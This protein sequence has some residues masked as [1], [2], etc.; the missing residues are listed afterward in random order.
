MLNIFVQIY[1][2]LKK[3]IALFV[4]ILVLIFSAIAYQ[5]FNLDLEEDIQAIIPHDERIDNLS[6]ALN[7]SKFSDQIVVNFSFKDTSLTDPEKLKT[8]AGAFVDMVRRDT[9]LVK[10]IRFKVDNM[11][12]RKVYGFFYQYLPFYLDRENYKEIEARLTNEEIAKQLKKNYKSLISPASIVTKRFLFKDPLSFTPV[13]LKKLQDLQL[14]DN[15]TIYKSCIFTSDRKNLLVFIEPQY[16]SG[17]TDKNEALISTIDTA[18]SAVVEQWPGIDL[19]YY[20]GTAVAVANAQRIKTDIIYTISIAV[21][22]IFLLFLLF[23]KRL[24]ILLLFFFPVI[25]GAGIGI[26]LLSVIYGEISAISLSIGAI[27]VGISIDYSLHAFTHFRSSGS[28]VRTLKD[29]AAPILISSITTGSAFLCLIVLKSDALSQ[30]GTF[31]AISVFIAAISVLFF[32]PQFLSTKDIRIKK[33]SKKSGL[34]KIAAYPIHEK[35]IALLLVLLLSVAFIFTFRHIQFNSNIDSL[36]YLTPELKQAEKDLQSIS[37]VANSTVFLISSGESFEKALAKFEA[38]KGIIQQAKDRNLIASISKGQ[39]FILTPEEQRKKIA[40]WNAFWD[41]IN[42]SK[43]LQILR[44]KG[45]KYHFKPKAF[46]AFEELINRKF[47]PV[48]TDEFDYIRNNFLDTYFTE[49]NGRYSVIAYVKVENKN[50]EELQNLF[51][52]TTDIVLFSKQNFSNQFFEIIKNQFDKLVWVT[53]LVVFIVLLIAYGRFELALVTFVPIMLS[54]LWTLGLIG[55]FGI[56]LN[57]FNIIISTFIFGLGVDYCIFITRGLVNNYKYGNHSIAPYKLSVLLSFITT[58]VGIGVLVFA[59]HPALKSIALVSVFG[60]TSVVIV[61]FTVLPVLFNFLIEFKGKRRQEPVTLINTMAS[62][63]SLI[64]FLISISTLTVIIPLFLLLSLFARRKAK[65]AYNFLLSLMSNFVVYI[66]NFHVTKREIDKHKLDFSK[67]AVLAANHQSHLD[68]VLL[69]KMNPRIIILTNHWV[70]H[71]KLF[72]FI[73]RFAD[74]YPVYKGLDHDFERISKKVNEGYSILVFP[75]GTRTNDGKIKRYH[76]GVFKIADDLNLEIQPILLHGAYNAMPRDEF[77]LRARNITLKYFDRFKVN[78]VNIENNETYRTQA[79]AFTSFVRQEYLNLRKECETPAFFYKKTINQYIFKGPVL[80]WYV[81]I[82]LRLEKNYEAIHQLI[83]YNAKIVDLGCGYGYM[84]Y[85]LRQLSDYRKITGYDYDVDKIAIANQIALKDNNLNFYVK[86]ISDD[87]FEKADVYI[88]ND[89][90]HYLPEK[91]QKKVI[92]KCMKSLNPN[93]I[94]IIRDADA[95]LKKR[96]RN[97]KITEFFSTKVLKFN[98]TKYE[99]TFV[100]GEMVEEIAADNNFS[101]NIINRTNL[102]PNV[103]F[104]LKPGN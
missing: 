82:K 92:G 42:R 96:T 83:P 32:L 85:M 69:M 86:D 38:N 22:F 78:S 17:N 19:N 41:R 80:E 88:I 72:G 66:M 43:I 4:I 21:I 84:A 77:F 54:W 98:Q 18:V 23:F 67:P 27:L 52:E 8:A 35:K 76:Q 6:M 102:T 40:E 93:G 101:V 55:L 81:K 90:L 36:N 5:L 65:Y 73:V 56:E 20:G 95:R 47:E 24:K 53:M 61:S 25:V 31:G 64:A 75:E 60:I 45:E 49:N 91:V 11:N 89:V 51:N 30:L 87:S 16:K 97:I 3:R 14:D 26:S 12:F 13:A 46:D 1:H 34:D 59:Q 15:F 29:V 2:Y 100:S 68:L 79:K 99:L 74:Y 103:T 28:I 33:G 48:P 39:N 50:K 70:W 63:A 10:K 71:S 37:S 58:T 7:N 62:F 44:E 94:I 57:I 104:V 9:L